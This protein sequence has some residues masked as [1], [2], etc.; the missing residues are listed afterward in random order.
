VLAVSCLNETGGGRAAGEQPPPRHES[1]LRRV[2]TEILAD[3]VGHSRMGWQMLS[4]LAPRID[5]GMRA[6]LGA[7]LVPAFAQL[8]ERHYAGAATP[9]LPRSKRWASRIATIRPRCSSTW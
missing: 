9:H 4:H 1:T 2:L 7:Y 3:E 8:F 6:R 5:D